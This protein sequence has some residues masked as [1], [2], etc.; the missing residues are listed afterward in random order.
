MKTLFSEEAERLAALRHLRILDTL[1]EEHFEAVCRTAR[2]LFGVPVAVVSLLDADRQW[3]KTRCSLIPQNLPRNA[4][5][6]DHTIRGDAVLVVPDASEDPR[7]A[8]ADLVSGGPKIRFYAGAPLILRPGIR[9]GALCLIDTIPRSFC[10]SDAA[11]LRDLAAIVVAHLRLHEANVLRDEEV[12]A[13]AAHEAMIEAQGSQ[14]RQR[15]AAL[16]GANRLLTLAEEMT[17]IG[18]WRVALSDGR[19]IWSAGAYRIM[20]VEQGWAVPTLTEMAALYH[21]DDRERVVESVRSAARESTGYDYEA[22]IVRPDGAVRHVS[23]GGICE[24]DAEGRTVGLFGTVVDITARKEAAEALAHSEARYR[25]LAEALPLLVWTTRMS[26][27]QATF[28]NACFQDY[29][30][31]I[32]SERAARQDRNHPED[33]PAIEAAWKTAVATGTTLRM[34]S[35]LRRHDG[36]YRWHKVVMIPVPQADGSAPA[37]WLGTALDIDDI[38][39]AQTRLKE[40]GDLLRLAL[41]AADAGA[42]DFDM[43]TGVISL[44]PEHRRMYGL[45]DDSPMQI[46][47]AAWTELVH[48]D[49]RIPTWDAVRQAVDTRAVYSAEYRIVGGGSERWMHACGRVL[50]DADGRPFRMVGLSFDVTERKRA[51][52]ALQAATRAAEAARIEAE[53]ASEAK[54]EFLAAMSH[55][56][57]TPLNGILGY[58]DLLLEG[59]RHSPEDRHRLELIQGSGA[60]LL[61]VVNDILDFSKIEAGQLELDPITFPLHGLVDN[62]VSIVRGSALKSP[63]GIACRLDPGLPAFVLGD[64]SRLR[65]VLLNLLN[66]AVKFTPEGSVTLSVRHEGTRA[67]PTGETVEAMRFCVADTGIGIAPEQRE[68]LFKRF[69]QVDGSISRRFGGSGLGLAICRHLVTMMGGEIGVESRV[70]I[71]ST[72]WFTLELPRREAPP[73]LLA[74]ESGAAVGDGPAPE[75]SSS[76]PPALGAAAPA[77]LLLVEDVGIN[78]E[79]ARAVLEIKGHRV[80]VVE[81]GSDAV[82]AVREAA[83]GPEPYDLVLMDVQMPGMDGLTATRLIRALPS[84]ACE[85]PVVAMTANVLPQ[86][87]AD[88]EAAGM[89]G[90]VGKPFKRLELY[91]AIDRWVGHERRRRSAD[92]A[93]AEPVAIVREGAILDTQAFATLSQRIGPMRT[94]SLLMLLEA[95]LRARFAVTDLQSV[96]T[97]DRAQ[98][99]QD[100]HAMVSAAGTLGFAGMSGLCREIEAACRSGTELGPLVR[101]LAALRGGT[102]QTIQALRAA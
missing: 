87:I 92:A 8:D 2:R 32:G 99:A 11:A 42:W 64:A 7:F 98:L 71:G 73:E 43:R 76:K 1:P 83:G 80:D 79:L 56:I 40:T 63:L 100:A 19:P 28:T 48:P 3:L 39:T 61:T 53:R 89:D 94:Q 67:L 17:Q 84:P 55:E 68:R 82:A 33:R 45:A 47:P 4:T 31:P 75:P 93:P 66:N 50:Y 101:R 57:R 20:G 6:C 91:A 14:L 58:A 27:G 85:V 18:H 12:A 96:E 25:G 38:I 81:D 29:C 22:R 65:Q 26:D 74:V 24:T 51:E 13:R 44:A 102:I 90:H 88:L 15:E 49:D 60:A 46:S 77:R 35:R 52:A 5:V 59:H 95:E 34:E 36:A 97:L 16:T 62:T 41:E 72:F 23:V 70:G 9:L 10:E 21:P 54:S 78:Q 37:E 69:S 86:Q 30:G